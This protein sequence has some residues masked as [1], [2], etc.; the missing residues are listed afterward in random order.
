[1]SK[2][3]NI[4]IQIICFSI[5][6]FSIV[7]CISYAKN[8]CD[9]FVTESTQ[10][11]KTNN[12][13]LKLQQCLRSAGFFKHYTNTLYFGP[14]TQ[15]ALDDYR[16]SNKA[17]SMIAKSKAS[18]RSLLNQNTQYGMQN[19]S[20][21]LLQNCLRKLNYFSYPLNTGF[22]GDFTK[23]SVDRYVYSLPTAGNYN[24][25]E[26]LNK[27]YSVNAGKR[28]ADPNGYMIGECVSLIKL[29][30]VSINEKIDVWP[31]DTPIASIDAYI[32]G[33][34]EMAL[35][36]YKSK[37]IMV[38]SYKDIRVGDIVVLGKPYGNHVGIATGSINGSTFE[39]IEQ[40]NPPNEG[41]VRKTFH[42]S[43]YIKGILRYVKI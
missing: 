9:S 29:W 30:Q 28:V 11:G 13:V 40:N 19:N 21:S 2:I 20:V 26:I 42:N 22:Y 14:V 35:G 15:K 31:G 6:A 27:F 12:E 16:Y 10:F 33:N 3:L 8:E 4:P 37:V 23:V 7:P 24:Y 17:T 5:L 32:K 43:I 25:S 41:V 18:C 1:M 34:H 39:M 38:S 36:G